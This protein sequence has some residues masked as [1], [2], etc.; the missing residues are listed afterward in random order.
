MFGSVSVEESENENLRNLC[1][2]NPTEYVFP[3]P[4]NCSNFIMCSNGEEMLFS[5]PDGLQFNPDTKVCDFATNVG[6]VDRVNQIN[7]GRF[8][9]HYYWRFRFGLGTRS[10]ENLTPTELLK[11]I[12]Q[13]VR[14]ANDETQ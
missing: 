1:T 14:S 2:D 3:D 8:R 11:R 13:L 4:D 12:S 10:N 7:H 9:M 5:C 6:C